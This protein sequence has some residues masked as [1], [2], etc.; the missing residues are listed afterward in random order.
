MNYSALTLNLSLILA[1]NGILGCGAEMRKPTTREIAPPTNARMTTILVRLNEVGELEQL[2]SAPIDGYRL[3][4]KR[5]DPSCSDFIDIDETREWFR[6]QIVRTAD[7][8]CSLTLGLQLGTLAND[9]KGLKSVYFQNFSDS[10]P[11]HSISRTDLEGDKSLKLSLRLM[12]TDAGWDAGYGD[13]LLGQSSDIAS[14]DSLQTIPGTPPS[15]PQRGGWIDIGVEIDSPPSST[16]PDPELV[17][18]KAEQRRGTVHPTYW[19]HESHNLTITDSSRTTPKPYDYADLWLAHVLTTVFDQLS[20][21]PFNIAG[22]AHMGIYNYRR[23]SGSSNLSRHAHALAI[24][25]SEF[26]LKDGT[27]ITVENDWKSGPHM[28][29]LRS[30][31]NLLCK[32]FDV[33]LSPDYNRDHYNHFHVDLDPKN[34]ATNE[35]SNPTWANLEEKPSAL[36]FDADLGLYISAGSLEEESA[37]HSFLTTTSERTCR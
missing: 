30:I 35:P 13:I 23:I 9:K 26:H 18:Y 24:D 17:V 36:L 14:T 28:Q 21:P 12:L 22:A 27:K 16:Q 32:N 4:I 20:K 31:R 33:V 10:E 37:G 7:S 34:R 15:T 6:G 29:L 19:M 8:S 1:A 11:G 25:L 5:L 3:T 2:E